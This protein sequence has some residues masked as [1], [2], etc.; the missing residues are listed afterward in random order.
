METGTLMIPC[1]FMVTSLKSNLLASTIGREVTTGLYWGYIFWDFIPG[2]SYQGKQAQY[3]QLITEPRPI[4][5]GYGEVLVLQQ[6][7]CSSCSRWIL[8]L[9]QWCIPH[10]FGRPRSTSSVSKLLQSSVALASTGGTSYQKTFG[11]GNPP[12]PVS[13][14]LCNVKK[15]RKINI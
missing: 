12:D 10:D 13:K 6:D 9:S 7:G 5:T 15:P 14:V 2:S 11:P 3:R 4:L 1:T 8:F